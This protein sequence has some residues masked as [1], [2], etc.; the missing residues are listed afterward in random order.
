M[1]V[2]VA[3][4]LETLLSGLSVVR[5]LHNAEQLLVRLTVVNKLLS[6]H[7]VCRSRHPPLTG[8]PERAAL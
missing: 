8:G 7:S 2:T 5:A 6:S 4:E 3:A 1:H